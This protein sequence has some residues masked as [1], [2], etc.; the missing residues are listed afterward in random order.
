MVYDDRASS[1]SCLV[2]TNDAHHVSHEKH[3]PTTRYIHRS[4]RPRL[5][6]HEYTTTITLDKKGRDTRKDWQE[7]NRKVGYPIF[8]LLYHTRNVGL[9]CGVLDSLLFLLTLST[10]SYISRAIG[11]FSFGIALSLKSFV[12]F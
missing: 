9:I 1:P 2:G 6:T 8:V 10:I 4:D 7:D 11:R 5:D 3:A 12:T